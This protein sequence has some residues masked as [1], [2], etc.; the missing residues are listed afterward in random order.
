MTTITIN[1]YDPAGRFNFHDNEATKFFA[2]VEKL[3]G[4]A[5][6]DVDYVEAISVDEFSERFVE[7]ALQNY[8]PE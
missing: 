3:A 5:G 1:T 2:Y 4:D 8:H 6:Y 7:K